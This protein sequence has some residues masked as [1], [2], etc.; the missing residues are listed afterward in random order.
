MNDQLALLLEIAPPVSLKPAAGRAEPVLWVKT[1]SIYKDWPLLKEN[2]LR[3]IPLHKGLNI[4]WAVP[5]AP[6]TENPARTSKISGHATGKT[7]FCRLVRY[8]LGDENYGSQ[9]A[10]EAFQLKFSSGWVIAEV[11]LAGEQWLVGRP[12]GRIGHH[13]FA[14]RGQNIEWLRGQE[15]R[16]SLGFEEYEKA[17]NATVLAECGSRTLASTGTELR[18]D[19]V[20]QWLARDQESRFSDLLTWRNKAS[21][22]GA[23]E[24]AQ[25][26]KQNLVRIILGFVS[27][28]EQ[29]LI[30][31]HASASEQHRAAIG[32]RAQF[33]FQV[34]TDTRRLAT[35]FDI[36]AGETERLFSE[37][38]FAQHAANWRSKITELSKL[39]PS[40]A[41]IAGL[42]GRVEK[43]G[44]AVARAEED[45][46]DLQ[47][48]IARKKAQREIA[49]GKTA[50]ATQIAGLH[51]LPPSAGRCSH[52]LNE[53]WR[54]RCPL[55]KLRVEDDDI[56]KSLET[57][58]TEEEFVAIEIRQLERQL[59]QRK[60]LLDERKMDRAPVVSE[61]Q[62]DENEALR[63]RNEIRP[64]EDRLKVADQ[65]RKNLREALQSQE[66][67]EKE[68]KSLEGKKSLLDEQLDRSKTLHILRMGDFSRLYDFLAKELL[69][70]EV[71][72]K[73]EFVGKGI[74]P[75][76]EF[77]GRLDSAA[78][79]TVRLLA[80]DLTAMTSSIIGSGHHPRFLIHDSPREADLSQGIYQSI[81]FFAQR[82]VQEAGGNDSASFQY[83]IT[84]TEPPPISLQTRDWLICEPL[85]ASKPESRLLR[86]DY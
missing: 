26:D 57:A 5:G 42:S 17:I 47:Q 4:L 1:L 49:Q 33:G 50:S 37:E 81:F 75:T 29:E 58:Q 70:G 84:T 2:E 60:T 10:R 15:R 7:T 69:G 31:K 78:L 86:I 72:A 14:V 66:E 6:N 40:A 54:A 16:P 71:S 63:I 62:R 74:D 46:S 19:L 30:R 43:L 18:W 67:N 20:L 39:T 9:R 27:P 65:L 3:T 35:L 55:A 23:E 68:I 24:M 11:I 59:A 45:F 56:R 73:V 28:E 38:V 52:E 8:V 76:V 22:S 85:D 34:E 41:K 32:K 77:H 48:L 79:E 25:A 13:P 82:L 12:L 64:F 21:E 51:G 36:A 83:I 61:L 44:L 53:A 80:F